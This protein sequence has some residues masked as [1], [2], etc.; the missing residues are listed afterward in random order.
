MIIKKYFSQNFLINK[1]IVNKIINNIKKYKLYYDCI[2]EIGPGYGI[3]SKKLINLN[4]K[5]LLIEIDKNLV[6]IL[7]KKFKIIKNNIINKDILQ[8]KLKNLG[9][10]KY[11]IVGNFPYNISTKILLWLLKN[12]KYIVECIGM[13]QKEFV[14]SIMCKKGKKKTKLSVYLQFFFN[15]KKLFIVKNNNFYPIPKIN[16]LVI[17]INKKKKKIKIII[18]INFF[19]LLNSVLNIKEKY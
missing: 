5:L 13:F 6:K 4:K 10:K 19:F 8:C 1:Y 17:K 11:Y 2:L 7:K 16:S 18:I 12:K 3:L 15:F 9:Y 14:E